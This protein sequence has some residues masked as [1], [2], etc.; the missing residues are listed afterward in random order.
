MFAY[1]ISV[2]VLFVCLSFLAFG[3]DSETSSESETR[4][5]YLGIGT[6]INAYTGLIGITAEFN[7]A[8]PISLVGAL[9][10]GSWGSK[11]SIG[12]RYYPH[13]PS[14]WAFTL[15]YSHC[16]GIPDV[17]V[18]LEEEFVKGQDGSETYQ[19]DMLSISTV[20]ISAMKHWLIGKRKVNRIHVE[21]GYAIPTSSD[22]YRIGADLTDD[23]KT[24]MQL[25]QPGGIIVGTGFTFG[26]RP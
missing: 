11:S 24:F 3:Q 8:E 14:Q 6:G 21:F 23:G 7:V 9:G 13:Y 12:I 26:L 4:S 1:K 25:L 19:V 2:S 18:K 10:I 22:R 17:D 5:L 15:S 16:S 20:N